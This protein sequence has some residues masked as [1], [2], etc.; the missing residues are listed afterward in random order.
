M[1]AEKLFVH[2]SSKR[3]RA[4]RLHAGFVYLFGVLVLAFQLES[5]VV[6]QVAAFVVAAE[7]PQGVGVP[8]LQRP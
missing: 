5:E 3:K 2:D 1:N 4:K 6:S 8:D 7:K